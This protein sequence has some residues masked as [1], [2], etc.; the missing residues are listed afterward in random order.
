VLAAGGEREQAH[1]A[2]HTL[3][4]KV[5]PTPGE[6]VL[7]VDLHGEAVAILQLSVASKKDS[8]QLAEAGDEGAKA[9]RGVAVPATA[10][11]SED[12]RG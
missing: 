2:I 12:G 10:R 7:R 4:E 3:I 6:G 1:E 9:R 5:V 11:V 8:L